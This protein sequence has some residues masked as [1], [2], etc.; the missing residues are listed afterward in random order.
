MANYRNERYH[1]EQLICLVRQLNDNDQLRILEGPFSIEDRL[2]EL[3]RAKHRRPFDV[4]LTFPPLSIIVETKVDSDEGG[5]WDKEWQTEKIVR[6]SSS[7]GYLEAQKEFRFITYGTSEFYTKP[8]CKPY[9]AGPASPEFVHIGLECMINLVESATEVLPPCEKRN[10]WVRLMKIER[11]KRSKSIQLLRVFSEFRNH[12]LDIHCDNDFPNNRF[13]FCTPEL[14]FPALSQ[15]AQKWN[16]SEYGKK[17][18]KLALYPIPRM[19][20]S[21]P[22]SVLNFW[23]LWQ[24]R[25]AP[26][27]G[28][29]I[30]GNGDPRRRLYIEIN[31]DFNLNLKTQNP[32]LESDKR[33]RIWE[34]LDCIEWKRLNSKG[35]P[36]NYTQA[37]LALYEID[38]GFLKNLSNMPQVVSNLGKTVEAVADALS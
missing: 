23:E 19:S 18:G 9:E 10:E 4:E 6:E 12:Y 26:T 2:G 3:K 5:R 11:E 1:D 31:E 20:P 30:V 8:D 16:G 34:H 29:S 32:D 22:D 38:F 24:E 35:R 36:R 15:L 37:V 27:I 14:A 33:Q 7:C 13:V 28:A 25:P 21:V 17:F